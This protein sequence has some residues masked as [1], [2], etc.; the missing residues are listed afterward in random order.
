MRGFWRDPLRSVNDDGTEVI[1]VGVSWSW[2]QQ[3][4]KRLKECTWVVVCEKGG[5]IEAVLFR[6]R[7]GP[8][9]DQ[10]A[11]G[12]EGRAGATVGSVGV[13]GDGGDRRHAVKRHRQR[14]RIFLVGP[15]APLA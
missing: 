2:C 15:A 12:V 9:I 8:A 4:S 6:A 1:N 11:G 7:N 13:G 10:R 3:V 14:Q 5:G